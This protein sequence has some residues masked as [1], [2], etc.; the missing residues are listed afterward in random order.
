MDRKKLLDWISSQSEENRLTCRRILDALLRAQRDGTGA[1]TLFLSPEQKRAA[2]SVLAHFPQI[3]TRFYPED[4]ER[5]VLCLTGGPED[6]TEHLDLK[7]LQIAGDGAL[8]HRHILGA[9]MATGIERD[10][11]GDIRTE[12]TIAQMLVKDSVAG[13]LCEALRQ[14]GRQR[15]RLSIAGTLAFTIREQQGE[16]ERIIVSSPRMDAVV[17]AV[18]RQA[19][20]KAQTLI[21]QGRIKRNHT[22]ETDAKK[23]LSVGDV[24]SVRGYGRYTLLSE[25]GPT[26]KGNCVF[27][28]SHTK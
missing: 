21:R 28:V 25:E 18:T 24:L 2:E 7:L 17:A 4:T 6:P 10:R 20:N 19:R 22:V 5:Q 26:R 8:S 3:R 12:D 1:C 16:T 15:V 23:T 13:Y 27:T 14:I 9:V 11:V